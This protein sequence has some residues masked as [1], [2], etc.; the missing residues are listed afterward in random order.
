[1]SKPMLSA[2][3]ALDLNDIVKAYT[4]GGAYVNHSEQQTGSLE[5]G[6][7]AD[8]VMLDKNIFDLPTSEISSAKVLLTLLDGKAVYKENTLSF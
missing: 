2:K 7:C 8:L 1:M 5:I 6:K 4:T 3:E